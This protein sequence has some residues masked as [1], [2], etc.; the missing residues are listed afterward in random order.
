MLNQP[1]SQKIGKPSTRSL[2][3]RIRAELAG[4]PN[5]AYGLSLRMCE[6]QKTIKGL[7]SSMQAAG[8]VKADH[9]C[10][11][12]MWALT[13]KGRRAVEGQ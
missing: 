7:L 12:I 10:R 11:P 5:S 8:F 3:G 6:T 4:T 1:Y 13:E 2:S 9:A